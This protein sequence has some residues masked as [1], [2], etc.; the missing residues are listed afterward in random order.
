MV[1]E[2]FDNKG[3]SEFH[4]FLASGKAKKTD[5]EWAEF[6]GVSRSHFN[7]LRNGTA[8]PSKTLMLRMEHLTGGE[9]SVISWFEPTERGSA[10]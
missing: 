8:Q 9:V 1:V 4:N 3:M 7:M 10:A 6:F 2:I 5:Q